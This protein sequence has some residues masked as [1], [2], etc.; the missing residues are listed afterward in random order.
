MRAA[1]NVAPWVPGTSPGKAEVAVV[2]AQDPF[3]LSRRT[4]VIDT[5]TLVDVQERK[6]RYTAVFV[7]LSY[8]FGGSSKRA[9]NNFDFGAK[10]PGDQ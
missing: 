9:A 7:G 3:G 6:F 5:P 8:T 10:A 2:T 4:N 1:E